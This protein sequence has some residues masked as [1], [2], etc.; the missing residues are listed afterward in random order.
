[1]KR[2][3]RKPIENMLFTV[4]FALF[5]MLTCASSFTNIWAYIAGW[6]VIVANSYILAKYGDIW[7]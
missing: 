6:I 2:K 5:V 1:M 3:L 7:E 4:T